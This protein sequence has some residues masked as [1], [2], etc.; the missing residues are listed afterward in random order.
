MQPW[1]TLIRN[2]LRVMSR[3]DVLTGR[4]ERT[5]ERLE[6]FQDMPM[7]RRTERWIERLERRAERLENKIERFRGD[8][9]SGKL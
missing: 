7:T 9:V 4:L 6:S 8:A 2:R 3:V 5:L 1:L